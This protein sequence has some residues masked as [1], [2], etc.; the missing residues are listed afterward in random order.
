MQAYVGLLCD[1]S[2]EKG[3]QPRDYPSLKGQ[4]ESWQSQALLRLLFQVDCL[5]SGTVRQVR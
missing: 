4:N 3:H 5:G 1:L 2:N